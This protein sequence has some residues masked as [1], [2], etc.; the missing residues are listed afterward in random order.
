MYLTLSIKSMREIDENF[1]NSKK[2]FP[3]YSTGWAFIAWIKYRMGTDLLTTKMI[4]TGQSADQ[5]AVVVFQQVNLI[6]FV[7]VCNLRTKYSDDYCTVLITFK[8][9]KQINFTI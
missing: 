5:N 7:H 9:K 4:K 2:T 8:I 1:D 3:N 6:L